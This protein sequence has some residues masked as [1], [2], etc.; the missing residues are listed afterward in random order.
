MQYIYF[1]YLY[2]YLPTYLSIYHLS[3]EISTNIYQK[4]KNYRTVQSNH[5]QNI[6]KNN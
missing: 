5:I 1:L 4:K 2:L 3:M 6:S